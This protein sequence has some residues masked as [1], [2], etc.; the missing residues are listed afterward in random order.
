M[1]PGDLNS[2]NLQCFLIDAK[3]DFAPDPSFRTTVFAGVPFVPAQ[4]FVIIAVDYGVL[5]LRYPNTPELIAIPNPA[6]QKHYS[7]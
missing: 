1:A 6:V 7:Q 2:P 5:A 4:P 3:V